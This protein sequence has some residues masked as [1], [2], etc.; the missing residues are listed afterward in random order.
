MEKFQKQYNLIYKVILFVVW[1]NYFK[2]PSLLQT[3]VMWFYY[4]CLILTSTLW[5]DVIILILQMKKR[6][7]YAKNLPKITKPG[8][9]LTLLNGQLKVNIA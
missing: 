8:F 3:Y 2:S 6:K 5:A 4:K 9:T 1:N 7:M